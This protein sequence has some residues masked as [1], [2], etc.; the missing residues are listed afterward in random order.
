MKFN[1]DFSKLKLNV[2][3]NTNR[4]SLLLEFKTS[5][6]L[7]WAPRWACEGASELDWFRRTRWKKPECSHGWL[8]S[9]NS[10]SI[11]SFPFSSLH[12]PTPRAWQTTA[13]TVHRNKVHEPRQQLQIPLPNAVPAAG[14]DNEAQG[15]TEDRHRGHKTGKV[16]HRLIELLGFRIYET[17]ETLKVTCFSQT[18]QQGSS[19]SVIFILGL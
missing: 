3:M 15:L 1:V 10:R 5:H 6:S 8:D 2:L 4:S 12:C 14:K 13:T 9:D 16:R 19:N 7:H 17:N 11:S 18:I